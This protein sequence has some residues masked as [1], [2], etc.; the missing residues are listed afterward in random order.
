METALD[1]S[2]RIILLVEDDELLALTETRWLR[3][4]GYKLLYARTGEEAIEIVNSSKERIDL[5]LMD[6][7][8]GSG[9]DGTEAASRILNDNDIPLL[10]LSSHTEKEVV[11]KTE[12]ITSYGYVVKDSN[13]VVLLASIKMAFKLY[14]ANRRLKENDDALSE[15][16]AKFRTVFEQ[17]PVGM[18][19]L[20][21]DRKFL[22]VNRA[23]V[24]LLGYSEEELVKKTFMDITHPDD[25][26]KSSDWADRLLNNELSVIDFEK[27]YISKSGDI[28]YVVVRAQ[29]RRDEN[30]EPLYFIA[31]IQNI[32]ER[33]R[34]ENIIIDKNRDLAALLQTSQALAST[35]EMKSILQIIVE[36]AVE[37]IGLDTGAIY[38]LQENKLY[39]GATT[40]PL[41]EDFPEIFRHAVLD[42]HPHISKS[43]SCGM[44]FA[45]SDIL[46][47]SFS[48]SERVILEGRKLRSLLY[49]PIILG[50]EAVGILLLGTIDRSRIYS[51]SEIDSYRTMAY[52]AALTIDN[53]R[54]YDKL[55]SQIRQPNF[56]LDQYLIKDIALES[57]LSAIGLA[58]IEGNL[59]YGNNA[60]FEMWG[61]KPE[62]VLGK[63]LSAITG[64]D[65]KAKFNEVNELL[66]KGER[67]FGECSAYKKDGSLFHVQMLANLVKSPS[68]DP[69]CMIA[70]FVD[71]TEKK[72]ALEESRLNEEKFR[73]FF[74]NNSAA[75]A[76]I[77]AD[78]T[79]SLVNQA[80]CKMSGYT[81]EEAIGLSW[82][83]QITD[84]DLERLKEY[85]RRRLINP[86][87]APT[88][89]E[90]SFYHKNGSVI[91]AL[92]SIAFIPDQRKIIASFTDITERKMI[93]KELESS[94]SLLETTLESTIDGILVVNDNGEIVRHNE[95]F[96][97]MWN[98]PGE[99]LSLQSDEKT[100]QFVLSQLKYP[101]K[102]LDK[103]NELYANPYDMSFDLIEFNDG[104]VF[105]RYSQPQLYAG[106]AV[107]RVWSFRDITQRMKSER[108]QKAIYEISDAAQKTFDSQSLYKKIHDVIG[109]LMPAKNFYIA[110]YNEKTELLSF[111][112]MVDEY[113]PFYKPKKLGK[114]LTEY[115]MRLGK[116]CLIDSQMDLQLREQKEVELIGTPAAIWLGVPL[117][118]DN[119]SI[120]VIAVQD[121]LDKKAY[122]KRDMQLLTFVS[123]QIAVAI[124]RKRSSEEIIK[125]TH[126]LEEL[127]RSKD[128][129]FSIISHDLKNPFH[130]IN[131]ALSLLLEEYDDFTQEEKLSFIKGALNTSQRA[132][133]LLDNLLIWSKQQMGKMEFTPE[134]INLFD[135]S[136]SIM[137]LFGNNA[138]LKNVSLINKIDGSTEVTA[139][140]NMLETV[141]RNLISNAIKYS[142]DN[143][144]VELHSVLA[145]N[146]A[147]VHVVD[148]G[149]GIE[150]AIL[151]NLFKIDKAVSMPGTRGET[152]TGLGLILC[153][154]FVEKN[155]GEFS[156][157]SEVNKGSRFSFTLPVDFAK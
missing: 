104:R 46:K 102:F 148:N 125:F 83:E 28:V 24:D 61:Y 87:D 69:L 32:T 137:A 10:F 152:G 141:L 21:L 124:E 11:D 101:D 22:N 133:A 62:E 142:R 44:P 42:D 128:L 149:L 19:L 126:E 82:T 90:F 145:G 37:L 114:G 16:E 2:G 17:A 135:I 85:N 150:P 156:V 122:S 144:K 47:E 146:Y 52:Q 7:N 66:M 115:V 39:L 139:D 120:G 13:E 54:L 84:K 154:E 92:I 26:S 14:S 1:F 109:T 49:V 130:S 4:A 96:I 151:N 38:L 113:D 34:A 97:E 35:L 81:K 143:G 107:G 129:F 100:L 119:K 25:Q 30:E 131:S 3:R 132:Y 123:E 33:K 106:Q 77:E 73:I 74:E 55:Q 68:G 56:D 15:S 53:A 140:R 78:T 45:V 95:K 80:Y 110:L 31:H 91:H 58:D 8:L 60:Y 79:I 98:I 127:N 43:L 12:T 103:V 138:S 118:I 50:E 93:E 117:I 116:A 136:E 94:L 51:E 27:R 23:L 108:L 157:K 5:I 86:E 155:R 105:E 72:I 153:K 20:G 63:N 9:I 18:V 121:Y 147:E 41:P 71:I 88:S 64:L 99:I 65:N 70:S 67:Y 75:I 57:S 89:Y 112:Y 76:I 48:P 40:P 59:I 111:P 29:L 134:K 6:I 36:K